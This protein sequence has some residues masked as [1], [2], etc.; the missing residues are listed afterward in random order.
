[1]HTFYIC[2]V[3]PIFPVFLAT[4]Q[5]G[6]GSPWL[7]KKLEK[8][9]FLYFPIFPNLW[10]T[11]RHAQFLFC[12]SRIHIFT[13]SHEDMAGIHSSPKRNVWK[14]STQ[15][16]QAPHNGILAS[17]TNAQKK[18]MQVTCAANKLQTH[19]Q[20]AQKNTIPNQTERLTQP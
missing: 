11:I 19:T 14:C 1:M 6:M 20:A 16:K 5:A 7:F 9:E 12:Q 13:D 18:L 17:H 15:G 10:A 2:Q 8:L 3:F 4:M